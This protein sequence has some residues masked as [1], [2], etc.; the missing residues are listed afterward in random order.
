MK[1]KAKDGVMVRL[2]LSGNRH[3]FLFGDKIIDVDENNVELMEQVKW[4]L[5]E[6]MA[7]AVSEKEKTVEEKAEESVV[8]V[9]KREKK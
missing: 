5:N 2:N 9:K 7:Y 8:T 3:E 6:G 1:I 4:L